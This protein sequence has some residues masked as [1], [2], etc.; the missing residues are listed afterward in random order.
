MNRSI[1]RTTLVGVSV[2]GFLTVAGCGSATTSKDNSPVPTVS[3]STLADTAAPD[4]TTGDTS[5]AVTVDTIATPATNASSGSTAVV[6]D[7]ALDQALNDAAA[8]LSANDQDLTDAGK[9]ASR[10]D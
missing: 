6:V 4:S 3:R 5:V 1:I 8:L 7:P 9:A 2:A 10:G